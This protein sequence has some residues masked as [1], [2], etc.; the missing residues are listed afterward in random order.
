MERHA[1]EKLI[2]WKNNKERKPLVIMGARQVG[3]TWLMKEF[4]KRYYKKVAYI[5][6][7]NNSSMSRVFEQDYDIN[8]I[9]AAINIEVGFTVT[10]EDTLIIFDEIQNAPKAFESLKYFNESAPE[11][12]IIV[13]GSLLVKWACFVGNSHGC[14]SF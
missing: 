7:Y 14:F 8:R 2:A 1:M 12:Q 5:S 6:F 3:K 9:I 10:K 4:G 11:Y 13:A